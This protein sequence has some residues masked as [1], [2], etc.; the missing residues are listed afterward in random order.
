MSPAR[1]RKSRRRRKTQKKPFLR[2]A[3]FLL[4]AFAAFFVVF[5][6]TT[7][8]WNSENKLSIAVP[9][10]NGSVVVSTFDPATEGIKTVVIPAETEVRVARQLGTWRI[11][12]VWELGQDEG[13]DGQLLSET[14]TKQFRIPVYV[15]GDS[16]G[17]GFSSSS[18]TTIIKAALFPYKT[19]LGI[20]DRLRLAAFCLGVKNF[21]REEIDLSETRVLQR[22]TLVDGT[23]GYRVVGDIPSS[24][25]AIYS[26]P[27]M[28]SI[29]AKTQIIDATSNNSVAKDVGE[30]VE[31]IGLK[32]ASIEDVEVR[33]ELDCEV[34]GRDR[35]LAKTISKLFSCKVVKHEE[36]N[37][38]LTILVGEEFAKRF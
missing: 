33:G 30:I 14:I 26:D 35:D 28:S 13:L 9:R 24:I 16:V 6:V 32:T 38:D 2:K 22:T 10:E 18:P 37:F 34:S 31:V 7:K 25:A 3:V 5:R 20:G 21:K 4:V 19:N 36:G 27:Y 8:H 23:P 1:R 12:S 11:K 15:W 29:S 17:S